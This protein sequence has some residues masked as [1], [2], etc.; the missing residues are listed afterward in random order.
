MLR[1]KSSV[2]AAMVLLAMANGMS[3]AL[4][5]NSP[6]PVDPKAVASAGAGADADASAVAAA[7]S[8]AVAGAQAAQK[9]AA[10]A[11]GGKATS[12]ATS[13]DSY[14]EGSSAEAIGTVEG[15]ATKVNSWGVALSVPAATAAPAVAGECLVHSRGWQ[16]G[17]GGAARSGGTKFEAACFKQIQCLQ[18]ADRLAAWGQYPMAVA[19]L[20][21]CGAVPGQ[22]VPPPAPVV[23]QPAAPVDA[24]SHAELENVIQQLHERQDRQFQRNVGK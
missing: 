6:A 15:D 1:S 21:S 5:T 4:A 12:S 8:A 18:L 10:Y 13:G 2:M 11:N 23:P 20:Q 3:V 14:S 19:Q 9:Q 16:A 24:V 7:K 22:Y 17:W